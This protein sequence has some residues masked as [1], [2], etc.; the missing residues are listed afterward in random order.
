M[1]SAKQGSCGY[2]FSK[3]FGMTQQGEYVTLCQYI[4][5]VSIRVYSNVEPKF[6][7]RC[8]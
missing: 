7:D 8:S 4:L 5:L 3:Y 1:L 2:H 6:C